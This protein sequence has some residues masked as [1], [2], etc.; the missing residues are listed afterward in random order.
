MDVPLNTVAD[1]GQGPG[2]PG[3]PGLPLFLDQDEGRKNFF[4]GR[5]PFLSQGLD[6]PLKYGQKYWP[7]IL[8]TLS[9]T[10][11]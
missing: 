7:S 3:G 5:P 8:K 2:G 9:E 6:P 1:P 11:I 10:K 4:W